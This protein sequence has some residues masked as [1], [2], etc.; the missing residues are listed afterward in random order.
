MGRA[1]Y[2]SRKETKAL[3]DSRSMKVGE[4]IHRLP[5]QEEE[6]DVSGRKSET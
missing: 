6:K 3:T 5:G 1:A 4:M 2:H